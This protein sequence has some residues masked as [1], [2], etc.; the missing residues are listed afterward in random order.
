MS[1]LF[2]TF[3]GG[4]GVGKTTQISILEE[5]LSNAQHEI[6]RTFE[7]GGTK[8][9]KQLRELLLHSHEAIGPKTEAL[10]YAADRA[11]HI[12]TVV[13]PALK[14][15]KIVLQDR[16]IDSSLA[17]Q[18]AGRVLGTEEIYDLNVWATGGLWP[19]LTVLLDL[20]P[21]VAA[22]RMQGRQTAADRIEQEK[23]DFHVAVR[24]EFL[25]IAAANPARFVVCDASATVEEI[26]DT[27]K[28]RVTKLI[29]NKNQQS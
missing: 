20:D 14:S 28:T 22:E 18:G 11:Q 4:D 17:Y 24:R 19:H 25:K 16:Y 6:V 7:P 3:E 26:A 21:L 10:L 12:E 27:I 13:K 1:G 9:G 15:N 5:W 2:I 23:N 29:E 8:M